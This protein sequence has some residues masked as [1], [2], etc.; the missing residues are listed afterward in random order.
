MEDLYLHELKDLYDAESQLIE[1]MPQMASKASNKTLK[2]SF[3]QHLKQTKEQR[4]HLEKIFKD[5]GED[6]SGGSCKGMKGLI[7]EGED[8]LKASG[9]E[10]VIDAAL[11]S[12]ANRVE[13]YE[14]AGYGTVRTYAQILGQDKHVQILQEIL[15]EEASTDEK[16]TKLAEGMVNLQ[17]VSGD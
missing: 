6:P 15:D 10:S 7:K 4:K 12:A 17:A 13:H 2:Q 9:D 11:I 1:A 14:I 3:E 8:I 5:L 16:L